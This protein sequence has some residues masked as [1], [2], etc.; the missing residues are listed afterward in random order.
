MEMANRLCIGMIAC[1]FAHFDSIGQ[2]TKNNVEFGIR[3][4]N[5]YPISD[6]LN[7]GDDIGKTHSFCAAVNLMKIDSTYNFR[8]RIETT[9]YSALNELTLEPRDIVF[10]EVNNFKFGFDNNKWDEKSFFHSFSLGVLY[11]QG[12]KI[13]IGATGQKYLAHS[14]NPKRPWIYS[15]SNVK[16][17]F[18]PYVELCYGKNK[19]LI[20]N[21]RTRLIM[22]N[23]LESIISSKFDFTGIGAR[24]FFDLN[25][26]NQRRRLHSVDFTLEGYYLTNITRFQTSYVELGACFNFRHFTAYLK[27]NKPISK[28]LGN[29]YVKYDDMEMQFNY[30]LVCVF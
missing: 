7:T 13:T 20:Q 4:D 16:D 14:L 2:I 8:F 5:L 1:F 22:M 11:I 19:T 23:N 6:W 30:G 28:Y 12:D 27:V 18:I 3:N 26:S 24:S 25:L 15:G 29:P 21:P 10:R 17:I 9:E